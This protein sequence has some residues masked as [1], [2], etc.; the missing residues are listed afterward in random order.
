MKILKYSKYSFLNN[1]NTLN[2]SEFMQFQFGI[3][4]M[5]TQGGGG[6]YAFAQDPSL[7]FYNYQDS[8]FSDFYSR[9]S[10]LVSNLMNT[11]KN[12]ANG[13]TFKQKSPFLEDLS[14]QYYVLQIV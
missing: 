1:H 6:Q 5:G 8:P 4:P 9:Q 3:E 13:G 14:L 2:E 12:L 11:V 10:G 7:S